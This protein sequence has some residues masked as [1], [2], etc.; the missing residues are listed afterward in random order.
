MGTGGLALLIISQ[1]FTFPGLRTIGLILYIFNLA[2]FATISCIMISRFIMYPGTFLRSIKHKKEGF[3]FPTIFVSISTMISGSHRYLIPENDATFN[4]VI[5][6]VFWVY[7]TI[8]MTAT[9]GQYSYVF[10]THQ[11]GL[12][13]MMPAWLLPVLPIM[14]AGTISAVISATQPSIAAT[15][16]VVGG[17]LSQGLGMIISLL[18]YGHM[19]GRLMSGTFPDR[20][21]RPALFI[22]VGPPSFTS[23]AFIGQANNL[24]ADFDIRL[25]ANPILPGQ[26][27]L[28]EKA[29]IQILA[30]VSGT[31]LWGLALWWFTI[32]LTGVV[33][34]PPRYFHLSWWG[35][36]FPNTGFALAT[37]TLGKSFANESIQWLGTVMSILVTL[38]YIVILYN[39]FWAVVRREIVYPGRDEDTDD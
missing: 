2:L 10:S 15:P 7:V 6:V 26:P 13:T 17:L 29:V 20:E 35:M 12:Q 37:I 3:F 36:I 11:F 30:Y 24:P 8:S 27:G 23:L 38:L 22:L 16:I 33:R 34:A 32:A 4:L 19:I 28:G 21:T 5:Q 25:G 18:M 1:P 9:I 31:L 39:C 14:L